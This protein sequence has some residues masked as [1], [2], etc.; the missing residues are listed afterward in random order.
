M[1]F[2]FVRRVSEAI[3][4]RRLAEIDVAPLWPLSGCIRPNLC[5]AVVRANRLGVLLSALHDLRFFGP[6]DFEVDLIAR[7]GRRLLV[8]PAVMGSPDASM[9]FAKIDTG[10]S[11]SAAPNAFLVGPVKDLDF[12]RELEVPVTLYPAGFEG[13]LILAAAA[14]R[15]VEIP[16]GYP[17]AQMVPLRD[18]DL[19]LVV[20]S[21]LG[22]VAA[23]QEFEGLFAPGWRDC[24]APRK[25]LF[26]SQWLDLMMSR[27]ESEVWDTL[28]RSRKGTV[29]LP[30]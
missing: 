6:R 4:P 11:L 10:L 28:V 3:C 24:E 15:S 13:P 8:V 1:I 9:L 22:S 29:T 18:E 2:E 27:T 5:P 14:R 7:S 12:S 17:L 21:D 23:D 20:P 30:G 16:A 26:A 25:R 19:E